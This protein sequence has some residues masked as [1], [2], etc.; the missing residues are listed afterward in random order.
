MLKKITEQVWQLLEI[1][2]LVAI[3]GTIASMIVIVWRIALTAPI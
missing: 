2:F 1:A 3:I